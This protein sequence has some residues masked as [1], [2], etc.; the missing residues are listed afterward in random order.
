MKKE[1]QEVP[2]PINEI[3]NIIHFI[4]GQKV[5]LDADLARLYG[6]QTKALNQALQRN[7][8]RLPE[9]FAFQLN[10]KEWQN[11]KSQIVTSS[12]WGGKRKIP[13]AFTEHGAIMMASLLKSSQA[14]TM[15]VEVVRAFI[16][17]RQF[18]NSQEN[19]I[20]EMN[21]MKEF[22]LK[23]SQNTTQEF[24]KVWKAIEKLMKPPEEERKIGFR[25]D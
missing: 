18:I 23:N 12:E 25:L 22:M 5:I 21:A 15:S 17:L 2:A 7:K 13:W 14:V 4:S 9:D 19:I 24:R 8:N 16:R 3:G 11:L 1:P 10:K 6:V 20:N